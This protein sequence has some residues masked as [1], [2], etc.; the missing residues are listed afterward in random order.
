MAVKVYDDRELALI[1]EVLDSG[2]LCALPGKYVP[3]FEKAFA[4]AVGARHAAAMN[5]A[6]SLLHAAVAASGAGAADEVICDPIV[7]FGGI[8]TMYNNAVPVFADVRPDTFTIDP[9]SVRARVTE[10]TKAVICTHLWGAPCDM[11]PIM[12]I[13]REHNL[14]VIEDCA[15]ALFSQYKGRY[16]GTL[17][18]VGVFS[19]QQS[20]HLSTG[21]GGAATTNDDGVYERVR[22]L[23]DPTFGSVARRLSWNYRMTEITAAIALV[24]LERARQ[25]CTDTAANAMLYEQAAQG[26]EWLV[27]QRVLPDCRSTYHFWTC[28]FDGARHGIPLDR[29]KAALKEAQCSVSVGYTQRPAYLYPVFSEPIA[30]G[31]GCPTRCPLYKGDPGYRPGACPVAEDILPRMALA[32]TTGPRE[33]HERNAERLAEV[34]RKL[35]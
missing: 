31:K 15:H 20:K 2:R 24:Q 28:L 35:S 34:A 32:Y 30:Y 7:Q 33:Q 5:S 4:G 14:L 29:F 1:K 6:M 3:M 12:E 19:F 16:T 11:D 17:G 8:A 9:E 23:S 13:A 10:R 22:G 26:V 25:Y 18:H 21:D 27:P